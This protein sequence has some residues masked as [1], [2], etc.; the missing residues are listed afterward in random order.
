[1]PPNSRHACFFERACEQPRR[2]RNRPRRPAASDLLHDFEDALLRRVLAA[3]Y[4]PRAQAT[5]LEGRDVAAG[6]V[7]DVR[8]RPAAF[9]SD[10]SGQLS[11]E[12]V[13]DQP[14][15][16]ISLGDRARSVDDARIQANQRTALSDV[17]VAQ[18]VGRDLCALVVVQ[19][20]RKGSI[21]GRQRQKRR[22]VE[23]ALDPRCLRGRHC[24]LQPADV[25]VI[26]VSAS[27]P[28]DADER[29]R[30][31]Y[32]VA[33]GRCARERGADP[34][35]RRRTAFQAAP[36]AVA[37]LAKMTSSCP[38]P[39]SARTIARPRKPVPPV[40]RTFMKLRTE[41]L[42]SLP[43]VVRANTPADRRRCVRLASRPTIRAPCGF[44]SDRRGAVGDRSAGIERDRA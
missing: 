37:A 16:K 3:E 30:V 44:A 21:R 38:R 23:H 7:V 15:E 22:R 25:D 17:F 13:A 40:R 1:M 19:F 11:R 14:T 34:A 27:P 31:Q 26:E 32:R 9:S 36:L 28:P 5:A 39:A 43:L 8:V 29:G 18:T 41:N 4:I 20:E 24:I 12:V 6:H 42:P 35:R 10:Q 2:K 33:A